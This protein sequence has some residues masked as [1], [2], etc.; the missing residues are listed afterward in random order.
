MPDFHFFWLLICKSTL[1]RFILLLIAS[2]VFS[3]LLIGMPLDLLDAETNIISLFSCGIISLFLL[4]FNSS[5]SLMPEHGNQNYM[6]TR[7]IKAFVGMSCVAVVIN[8]YL[9]LNSL[10]EIISW[11]I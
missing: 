4:G 3:G 9:M 5:P 10:D 2:S 11:R 1:F 7:V 6:N 8:I